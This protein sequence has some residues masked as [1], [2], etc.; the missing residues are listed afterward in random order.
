MQVLDS[1]Y[2]YFF[3]RTFKVRLIYLQKMIQILTIIA[4]FKNTFKKSSVIGGTYF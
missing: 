2:K 3:G 4:S 1:Y